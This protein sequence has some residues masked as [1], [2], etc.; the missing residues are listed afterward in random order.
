M[1]DRVKR[2]LVKL[3]PKR[4]VV[5]PTYADEARPLVEAEVAARSLIDRFFDRSAPEYRN[6]LAIFDGG[7]TLLAPIPPV[8]L[9]RIEAGVGLGL[10][11][12]LCE[13]LVLARR[14]EAL[15]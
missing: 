10:A 4:E 1:L 9:A 14:D 7:G 3:P 15:A 6:A 8:S 12:H 11:L 2:G 13:A 5:S